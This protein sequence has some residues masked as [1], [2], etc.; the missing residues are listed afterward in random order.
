M[1]LLTAQHSTG[2]A[3]DVPGRLAVNAAPLFPPPR[4]LSSPLPTIPAHTHLQGA[5]CDLDG[6]GVSVPG[7][8]HGNWVGPTI[9]SGVTTDMECYQQ[10]IFG[11]VLVCLEV[12]RG[13]WLAAWLA[14]LC[15]RMC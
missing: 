13:A 6:R 15:G 3:C 11:P 14:A 2:A 4:L 1:L 5:A 7:Y 12:G 9:L 10:E 8:P